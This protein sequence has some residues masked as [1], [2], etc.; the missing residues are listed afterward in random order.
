MRGIK[1]QKCARI[2]GRHRVGST[3]LDWEPAVSLDGSAYGNPKPHWAPDGPIPFREGGFEGMTSHQGRP[4]K[5]VTFE[6]SWEDC[7]AIGLVR[8]EAWG[9]IVREVWYLGDRRQPPWLDMVRRVRENPLPSSQ[10]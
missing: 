4:S 2:C 1:Y 8:S 3:G 5:E 6:L 10:S 9:C 7:T